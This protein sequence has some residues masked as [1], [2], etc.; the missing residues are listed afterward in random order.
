M[1]SADIWL[2]GFSG[3]KLGINLPASYSV[4]FLFP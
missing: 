2:Q 3:I 1:K 4:Q